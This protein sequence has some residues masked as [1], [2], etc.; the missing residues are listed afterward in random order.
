MRAQYRITQTAKQP[1]LPNPGRM[2][3]W[4]AYTYIEWIRQQTARSLPDFSLQLASANPYSA[5]IQLII[6]QQDIAAFTCLQRADR[7]LHAK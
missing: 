7:P 2:A 3:A 4:L 1:P 5:Q 6:Q